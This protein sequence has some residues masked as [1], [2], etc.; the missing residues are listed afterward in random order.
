MKQKTI[1]CAFALLFVLGCSSD[2]GND[3]N[4][5]PTP[6]IPEEVKNLQKHA[7]DDESKVMSFN[8][9]MNTAS[10][11]GN[12]WPFRQEACIELIK[13]KKPSV[14]GFQEAK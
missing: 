4:P 1:L 12:A 5:T 11:M 8:V 6:E 13:D 7:K 9:R 3:H 14:I 10:D 2:D